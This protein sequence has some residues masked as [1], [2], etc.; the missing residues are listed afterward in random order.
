[1][2]THEKGININIMSIPMKLT[3]LT[4]FNK[5]TLESHPIVSLPK[6]HRSVPVVK[7]S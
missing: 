1:M 6:N 4:M 2:V 7:S 5:N 3:N